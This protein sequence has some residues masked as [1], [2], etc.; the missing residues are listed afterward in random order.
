[1]VHVGTA[2]A[3]IVLLYATVVDFGIDGLPL[4]PTEATL[5]ASSEQSAK[6]FYLIEIQVRPR[7]I[8]LTG[9]PL[10]FPP[11]PLTSIS[12]TTLTAAAH[13]A[14]DGALWDCV[15]VLADAALR[16]DRGFLHVPDGRAMSPGDNRSLTSSLHSLL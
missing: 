13:L 5:A 7:G 4:A 3:V 1:M 12:P 6:Y 8:A 9:K 16:V 10:F 15:P 14:V 2:Q 11:C